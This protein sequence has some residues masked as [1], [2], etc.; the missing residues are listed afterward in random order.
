MIACRACHAE[1]WWA[2]TEQ[3]KRMPVDADPSP[4][5]NVAVVREGAGE[6]PPV[7]RV[8]PAGDLPLNLV[9]LYT[10]HFATCPNASQHRRKP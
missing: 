4:D 10:S 3:G 2:E 1:I 8:L 7:V 6:A 9:V 5:G